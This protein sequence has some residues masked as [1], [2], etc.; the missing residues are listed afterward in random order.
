MRIVLAMEARK[1]PITSRQ[2]RESHGETPVRSCRE[3]RRKNEGHQFLDKHNDVS[4]REAA[5]NDV[6]GK[7][8]VRSCREFHRKTEGH[9]ILSK[10]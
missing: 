10:Q 5:P 3:C 1:D 6:V 4:H 2:S 9:Q 8:P 7:V